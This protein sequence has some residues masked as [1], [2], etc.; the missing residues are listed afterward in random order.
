MTIDLP[1][2]RQTIADYFRRRVDAQARRLNSSS[3]QRID[4]GFTLGQA[5]WVIVVFDTRA[6]AAMDGEWTRELD[7]ESAVLRIDQ[8]RDAF[9]AL[10]DGEPIEVIRPNGERWR[11]AASL[12][13]L[14][15]ESQSELAAM[16]GDMLKSL[17]LSFREEGVFAALPLAEECDFGIEEFDAGESM[18]AWSMRGDGNAG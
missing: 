3:V 5:G 7:D 17:I 6:N 11:M 13:D 4:V 12:D 16:I 14:D 1:T 2:A 8:W 10:E 15:D 18:Y 9:L